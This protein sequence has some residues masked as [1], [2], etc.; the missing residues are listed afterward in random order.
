MKT[1]AKLLLTGSLMLFTCGLSMAAP[2]GG[3]PTIERILTFWPFIIVLVL[4]LLTILWYQNIRTMRRG[5]QDPGHRRRAGVNPVVFLGIVTVFALVLLA[6]PW[7]IQ[8]THERIE[9]ERVV[10]PVIAPED[11]VEITLS[12]EGMTCTGCEALI[13]RRVKE[14]PGVE[15]VEADHKEKTTKVVFDQTLTSIPE[16]SGTIEDAGYKVKE[17]DL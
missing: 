13:E 6:L 8:T 3:D 16:V 11:R 5:R 1:P 7:Y 2:A 15:S 14:L 9:E 17:D 12:V 4:L 10:T